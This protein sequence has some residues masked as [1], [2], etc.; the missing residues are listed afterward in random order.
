MFQAPPLALPG[1]APPYAPV[2]PR[3]FGLAPPESWTTTTWAHADAE[4]KPIPNTIAADQCRDPKNM[5]HSPFVTAVLYFRTL[6]LRKR[7]T[8]RLIA[9][10]SIFRVA[11]HPLPA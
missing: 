4:A 6:T 7:G 9:P 3:V 8:N 10:Q 5:T 2:N 1:A 11:C